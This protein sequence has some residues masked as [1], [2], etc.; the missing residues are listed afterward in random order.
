MSDSSKY[1]LWVMSVFASPSKQRR[2]KFVL[3]IV[4]L[5]HCHIFSEY[6]F[7]Y[8]YIFLHWYDYN[9]L[10]MCYASMHVFCC[11]YEHTYMF[12]EA[13]TST[14]RLILSLIFVCVWFDSVDDPYVPVYHHMLWFLSL[15]FL[16]L[17]IYLYINLSSHS[18]LFKG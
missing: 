5:L 12:L 6:G 13:Y 10:C 4:W 1:P 9:L 3:S 8:S 18:P 14:Y 16:L 2:S 7:I 11:E 17:L 15:C